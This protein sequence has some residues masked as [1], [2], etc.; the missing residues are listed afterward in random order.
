[1]GFPV[2]RYIGLISFPL[3]LLHWPLIKFNELFQI[4]TDASKWIVLGAVFLVSA[5][6]YHFA[7]LPIRKISAKFVLVPGL[8]IILVTAGASYFFSLNKNINRRLSFSR[9]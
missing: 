5:G 4:N 2:L 8:A 3:Y 6:F 7:E 1:M 9:Y